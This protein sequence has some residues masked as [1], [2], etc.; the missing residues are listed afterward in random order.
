[1]LKGL[2]NRLGGN[3]PVTIPDATWQSALAE[4]P[5]LAA[6]ADDER[7]RLRTL[8]EQFLGQKEMA[9]AADLELNADIQVRIAVQAVLPVL[10]L[11]LQWYR[12]WSSI[13][14]Y[15]G[16]FLVPR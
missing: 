6:L 11:G 3:T 9:G 14:V 7:G 16:E 8:T 2:L 12:G 1:M 15:P 10:N 5:F 13:V 4:L